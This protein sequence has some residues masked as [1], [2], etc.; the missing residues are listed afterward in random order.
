MPELKPEQTPFFP[1]AHSS[2]PSGPLGDGLRG[3]GSRDGTSFKQVLE[4]LRRRIALVLGVIALTLVPVV[5]FVTSERPLYRAT[6]ALRLAHERRALTV[7]MEDIPAEKDQ[8]ADPLLTL[9]ELLRSRTVAG[10]VVDSL[11]LRLQPAPDL[12]AWFHPSSASLR[13]QFQAVRVDPDAAEDTLRLAFGSDRVAARGR[14]SEAEAPYGSALVV[15][16]VRFT[17]LSAPRTTT[18]TLVV[19]PREQAIDSLLKILAVARRKST[20]IVDVTYSDQDAGQAQRVANLVV[21]TFQGID[22]GSAQEQARHRAAFLEKQF[23]ANRTQLTKAEADLSAFQRQRLLASSGD[24]LAAEE[25]S[26]AALDTRRGAL[27]TEHSVYESF[28]ASLKTSSDSARLEAL[29]DLSYTP[30]L[31]ADPVV[32]R[33]YQQVLVYQTRLDSLTSGPLPAAR[34]N[35]DVIQLK[36][37]I[38]ST[39]GEL[40]RAIRAHLASVEAQSRALGAL[41]SRQGASVQLLPA[42]KADEMRLERLV[43]ALRTTGEQ[44]R[45]EYDKARMAG[46]V[47]AGDVRVIDTATLPYK[48]VGI[49][50][51]A[52]L[53]LGLVVGLLLGTG[54]AGLAESMNTSITRPEQLESELNLRDLGV[55]PRL[56]KT[57]AIGYRLNRLLG[58]PPGSG[59]SAGNLPW[60]VVADSGEPSI[61]AEA[62]RLLYTGLRLGW[63]KGQRTI[64]VTSVAPQEG[65]TLIAANLAVTFAREGVQVL[66]VDCDVRRPRLHRLFGVQRAP[67][68]MELLAADAVPVQQYYSMMPG[69]TRAVV[70]R[71]VP[72]LQRTAVEGLFL[73]SCGAL[74]PDPS[75]VLQAPR[76]RSLLSDF[77]QFGA[78][79]L[80]TPPV[81]ACAD[82]ARLASLVDGTLLVVRAGG[83]DRAAAERAY[84]Y[85]VGAGAHVLGAVLNDPSGEAA[86]YGQFY[87]GYSYPQGD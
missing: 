3:N 13:A 81:L 55:I 22:A 9:V 76:L 68:L 84:Q 14:W 38:S 82:A 64:L 7:G 23:S 28:L 36:A 75:K 47:A 78:I 79:I 74:P 70:E 24:K 43:D 34:T 72:H 86:R 33:V 56:P 19:V 69:T 17:V 87:Y 30:E 32:S 39:N 11:G 41:K 25:T 59:G 53:G 61:G 1:S 65:K 58:R 48:P 49:P 63:G 16:R 77:S 29:R 18:A 62:F 40:V 10:A 12:L 52:K 71:A 5:A 4:L 15:G 83:T 45:Q 42:M 27:E 67:G 8:S 20:D 60:E 21:R 6:T 26:L 2:F 35:P 54:A 50:P 37:L 57:G 85:L 80:D 73:L 51:W 46:A 66:L 31:A 44:L